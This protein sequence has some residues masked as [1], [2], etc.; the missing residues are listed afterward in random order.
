MPRSHL[1]TG[2]FLIVLSVALVAAEPDAAALRV[3]VKSEG[4][5]APLPEK[6]AGAERDTPESIALGRQL[7]FDPRLSERGTQS[8]AS[9]HQLAEDR[10][11]VDNLR[12]SPGANGT[13]TKRNTP[14]VLN[15]GMQFAQFWDGRAVDLVAQAREPI[16]NAHEMGMSGSADV[17]K[18]FAAVP[19]YATAFAKAFPGTA[20]PVSFEHIAQALAAFERTLITRD[21]FDDFLKGADRA[22]SA[23]ELKGLD[24]FVSNGCTFCHNGPLLGGNSFKIL[25]E[26]I[27][28][29][30]S[31][32][33]GRQEFTGDAG[34]HLLFKVPSLRNVALTAPYFH[35]GSVETLEDAIRKMSKHQVGSEADDETVKSL[36]TFLRSLSDKM[37]REPIR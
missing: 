7:F 34:D 5:V 17:E 14:T 9:C 6:M 29:E 35:D 33:R 21:R 23:G 24:A 4:S 19:E 22:L 18:R 32:D 8:C 1:L 16:L 37:R 30:D 20:Q 26:E 27:P 36:A 2:A 15:A 12:V 11:G 13:L 31:E 28:Y 10:A 3:R 25:G